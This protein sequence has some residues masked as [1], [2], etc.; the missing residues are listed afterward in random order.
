MNFIYSKFL[1]KLMLQDVFLLPGAQP[2]DEFKVAL[3]NKNYSPSQQDNK[4]YSDLVDLGYEC[5]DPNAEAYAVENKGYQPGGEEIIFKLM[6]SDTVYTY[7]TCNN[8][9]WTKATI[10]PRYAIIYRVKD[11]LLISCFDFGKDQVVE[12]GRFAI[13]WN[14]DAV[15]T[16]QTDMYYEQP[17]VNEIA[18]IAVET[19][20]PRP[21]ESDSGVKI[22]ITLT[23]GQVREFKIYDGFVDEM[24]D[25]DS[26]NAVKNK[27]ISREFNRKID[28]VAINGTPIE[29]I[30]TETPIGNGILHNE[31][32]IEIEPISRATIRYMVLGEE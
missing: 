5:I 14:G 21:E 28:S 11:G 20:G 29:P 32:N 12:S 31:I 22:T 18:D 16:I 15:L 7:L 3:I 23:N 4:K 17:S 24:L 27:T 8:V 25:V 30:Q 6:S 10:T 2:A 9:S 26:E 1:E 19:F 13:N